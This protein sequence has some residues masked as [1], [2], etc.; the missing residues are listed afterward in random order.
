M[1][2]TSNVKAAGVVIEKVSKVFGKKRVLNSVDIAIEPQEFFTIIGPSGCGKTTLLRIISGFY[3]PDGGRI[4]YDRREVTYIPPWERQIGFVFQNYALWPNMTIFDN[5]AYGLRIRKKPA[6]YIR[7]KVKWALGVVDLPGIEKHLPNQLSG[8]MQQR[9]A[10]ARA[11]VIDPELLLL[12][13]PLSNLDAKLRISLRKQIREIQSTLGITAVYVTH[14]QEEALEIADRIAVMDKGDLQQVGTPEEVY[15]RPANHLVASFVG[16]ANFVEGRVT[17]EGWFERPEAKLRVPL[18]EKLLARKVAPGATKMMIRPET[19]RVV[20]G[21]NYHARGTIT[22]RYY[23]G[24]LKRYVVR[25][26]DNTELVWETFDDR[27]SEGEQ[28]QL[29]F[30]TLCPISGDESNEGV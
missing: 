25:L 17:P 21:D 2:P 10:I 4:F 23:I 11:I 20:E 29:R 19:I 30:I 1:Q 16:E 13:E 12:D 5:V 28:V 3:Q 22:K 24:S 8:G 27:Y 6:S 7:D 14:D 15:E 26:A 18:D 9:V